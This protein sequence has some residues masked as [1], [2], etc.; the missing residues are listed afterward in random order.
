MPLKYKHQSHAV[1][2]ALNYINGRRT[3]EIVSLDTG[4]KKLNKALLNGLEWNKIFSIGAMS[5]SGKSVLCE[6]LKR[7]LTSLNR[8]EKFKILSFEFEMPTYQNVARSLSSKLNMSTNELYSA[9]KPISDEVWKKVQEQSKYL[10]GSNVYNVEQI[11]SVAEIIE[12]I[13]HFIKDKIDYSNGEGVV[14]TIDHVLL[15]KQLQNEA[16]RQVIAN[17]YRS[18]IQLKKELIDSNIKCFFILLNQL[19]RKIEDDGRKLNNDL[20]YPNRNDLF[21]SNDIFMGSDYVLIIHKPAILNLTAYGPENFPVFN[22]EGTPFLYLHLIKQRDG[23]PRI[24]QMIDDFKNSR[25]LEA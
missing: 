25:I 13:Q 4:I 1:K 22:S 2:R 18:L 5:G 17:L 8:E 9:E 24:L 23:R 19:N 14:V 3:G 20:H 12:T 10:G 15:T 16:E 7:N 21:G 11:G 6:Q